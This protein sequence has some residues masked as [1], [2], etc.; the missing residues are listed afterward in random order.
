MVAWK[1]DNRRQYR[2][3]LFSRSFKTAYARAAVTL[4]KYETVV[5]EIEKTVGSLPD[6]TIFTVSLVS[7][8][9]HN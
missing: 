9:E 3:N 4:E 1:Q 7:E 2:K 8:N 6:A 5:V